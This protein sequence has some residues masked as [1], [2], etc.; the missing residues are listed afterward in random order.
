LL[1]HRG[2]FDMAALK[3]IAASVGIDADRME[4]DMPSDATDTVLRANRDLAAAIGIEA[5]PTFVIGD[6]VFEGAIPAETLQELV[7]KAGKS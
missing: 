6:Q 2:G 3:S 4:A 5:T 7:D 1:Q